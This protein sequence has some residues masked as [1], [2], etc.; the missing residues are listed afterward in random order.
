MKYAFYIFSGLSVS[1][2]PIFY[3]FRIECC[4]V[5]GREIYY[6]FHCLT[7]TDLKKVCNLLLFVFKLSFTFGL[8]ALEGSTYLFSEEQFPKSNLKYLF[9]FIIHEFIFLTSWNYYPITL[10]F[11]TST[12]LKLI[13]YELELYNAFKF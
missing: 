12:D 8:V 2:Y 13:T 11:K 4:R 6:T 3:L 7:W 10:L 9:V 5:R 1:M